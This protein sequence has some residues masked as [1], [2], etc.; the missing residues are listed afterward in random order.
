MLQ[1]LGLV[2]SQTAVFPLPAE[3]RL[4]G[5]TKLPHDL[6]HGLPL[7][8]PNLGLT[9]LPNDLLR[10]KFFPLGISCPPLG[11]TAWRFSH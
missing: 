4:L 9:E 7:S 1:T 10:R 6:V 3:I 11:C 5:H 8:K 2:R